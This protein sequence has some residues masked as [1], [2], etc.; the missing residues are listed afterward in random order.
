MKEHQK[1]KKNAK[2]GGIEREL[3]TNI[4]SLENLRRKVK[5]TVVT[6]EKMRRLSLLKDSIVI[7]GGLGRKK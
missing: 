7:A 5:A 6:Y 3:L 1:K 2:D 4:G